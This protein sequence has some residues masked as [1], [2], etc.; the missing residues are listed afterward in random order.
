MVRIWRRVFTPAVALSFLGT[1]VL[2]LSLGAVAVAS[3]FAALFI[4]VLVWYRHHL[5]SG[6]V[7]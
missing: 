5:P 3:L 4:L 7:D 2:V 6:Y 1:L